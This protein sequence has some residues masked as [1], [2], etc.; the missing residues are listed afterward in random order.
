MSN[1]AHKLGCAYI[2]Q[3][4]ERDVENSNQQFD[5]ARR[6]AGTN[7]EDFYSMILEYAILT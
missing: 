5:E 3:Y 1:I 4:T 7:L 6:T 2:Y